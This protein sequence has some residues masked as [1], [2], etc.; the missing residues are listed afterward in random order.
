MM[1]RAISVPY[2]TL[3]SLLALLCGQVL[4]PLEVQGYFADC[5]G[6]V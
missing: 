1:G 4:C 2:P 3:R 5:Y 6:D